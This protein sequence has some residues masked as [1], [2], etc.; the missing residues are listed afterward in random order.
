MLGE[1][2]EPSTGLGPR[3]SHRR[4]FASYATPA[5]SVRHTPGEGLEPSSP[6]AKTGVLPLDDPGLKEANPAR[7]ERAA[8]NSASLRSDPSEL[9]VQRETMKY[10]R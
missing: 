10:E 5:K 8:S 1:G 2:I 4:A 3:R 6:V 9:R 7:L